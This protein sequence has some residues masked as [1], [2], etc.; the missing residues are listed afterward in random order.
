MVFGWFVFKMG[1]LVFNG[2]CHNGV[3]VWQYIMI[4][5]NRKGFLYFKYKY[6]KKKKSKLGL[7]I[8]SS[9]TWRDEGK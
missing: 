1:A 6:M 4:V 3:V 2:G 5:K 8:T 7:I 9:F